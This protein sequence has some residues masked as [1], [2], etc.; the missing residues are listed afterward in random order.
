MRRAI[1]WKGAAQR[2]L[3]RSFVSDPSRSFLLPNG[4]ALNRRRRSTSRRLGTTWGRNATRHRRRSDA[5][6]SRP[7]TRCLG[8]ERSSG[9]QPKTYGG[10]CLRRPPNTSRTREPFARRR[11]TMG[12]ARFGQI[13]I[14]S[15]E[16]FSTASPP[17]A[18]TLR[19][20]PVSWSGSKMRNPQSE[21]FRSGLPPIVFSNS[22]S[23]CQALHD[24]PCRAHC[25][26]RGRGMPS[27]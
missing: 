19:A 18:V 23:R 24:H 7:R 15:Y 21:Y 13:E 17:K 3:P 1:H 22:G 9:N 2:S 27:A 11:L 8:F 25:S 20:E 16:Q 5:M 12:R 10:G 4:T 6:P 26:L 14:A